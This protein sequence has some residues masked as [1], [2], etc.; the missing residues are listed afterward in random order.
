MNARY[1]CGLA[2]LIIGLL[3]CVRGVELLLSPVKYEATAVIKIEVDTVSAVPLLDSPYP[4]GD[5]YF[6]ETEVKTMESEGILSNVVA[7]LKL[8]EV[9]GK[10]YNHGTLDMKEAIQLLRW[11]L[12]IAVWQN[13]ELIK[14]GV[15]DEDPELA[16][17]M[18]N[19]IVRAYSDFRIEEH[20]QIMAGG[21]EVLKNQ[22]QMEEANLTN[23]QAQFDKLREQ[24]GITN[25]G[26]PKGVLTNSAAI[27]YEEAKRVLTDKQEL[28]KMLEEKVQADE[29]DANLPSHAL[30]T[31]I[32]PA[33]PYKVVK[34]RHRQL[35]AIWLAGGLGLSG[36]GFYLMVKPRA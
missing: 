25:A 18:A 3:V 27:A 14:I 21:I 30:V 32:E 5:P 24:A 9:W 36:L 34:S 20:R 19:G 23:L 31:V 26:P 10:H 35:G 17:R 6:N 15:W 22:Y 33:D 4:Y 1:F 2:A 7:A 8:D 16:A 28:H 29:E 13:T 12:D 11:R